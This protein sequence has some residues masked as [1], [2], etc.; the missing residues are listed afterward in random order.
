MPNVKRCSRIAAASL[1]AVVAGAAIPSA[2]RAQQ[3]PADNTIR[4]CYVPASGTIYRIGVAG[5]PTE[6]RGGHIEMQWNVAGPAGTQGEA[7]PAGPVGPAGPWGPAGPVSPF[8]P[9]G[10]VSPGAPAGPATF[11]FISM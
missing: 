3:A 5:A 8:G 9:A 10:P 4:A 7:G 6:C 1:L 11:H 2:A